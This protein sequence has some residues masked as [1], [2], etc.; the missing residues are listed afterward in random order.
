[1]SEEVCLMTEI[2]GRIA[3]NT[4]ILADPPNIPDGSEVLVHIEATPTKPQPRVRTREPGL[5]KGL[6]EMSDDFN[7]TPP[8]FKDYLE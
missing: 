6:I 1:M 8:D 3:G 7:D 4:I 5:M 2:R